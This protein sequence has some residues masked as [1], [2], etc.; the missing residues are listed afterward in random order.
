MSA[1]IDRKFRPYWKNYVFQSSLAALTIFL[2]L[3]L[4]NLEHV[5]VIAA[6]GATAFI[7]FAMPGD[8]TARSR[9]IIGGH[10]VGFAVGSLCALLPQPWVCL[11]MLV[12]SLAVG[13]SVLIMVTIDTEHPPAAA[14]ALGMAIT[15]F[16]HDAAVAV[17]TSV[18]LLALAHHFLKPFFKDL[19]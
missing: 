17:V 3:L 1:R 2:L 12:Y 19:V 16:S 13:L 9:N 6:I 4:L 11:S 15:G 18:I 8:I 7:V 10:L 5:V 14:T